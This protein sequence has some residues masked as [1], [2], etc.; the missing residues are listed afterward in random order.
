MTLPNGNHRRLVERLASV[1]ALARDLR[2][3]RLSRGR[4]QRMGLFRF[5]RQ[6]GI[7]ALPAGDR[8]MD[9][10]FAGYGGGGVAIPDVPARI[11]VSPGGDDSAN[12]QTALDEVSKMSLVDG[13]RGAVQIDAREPSTAIGR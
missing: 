1:I 8:I 2:G 6:A 4:R 13:R 10:S 12:I 5:R 7:C 11:T 3:R 9:F